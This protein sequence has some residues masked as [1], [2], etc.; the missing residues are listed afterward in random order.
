M[1]VTWLTSSEKLN[2]AGRLSVFQKF[3]GRD[4][5]RTQGTFTV[6]FD[7]LSKTLYFEIQIN[8]MK[9]LAQDLPYQC[10]DFCLKDIDFIVILSR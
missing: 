2:I 9:V 6:V 8:F 7:A 10:Q 1:S 4:F 3:N 5:L